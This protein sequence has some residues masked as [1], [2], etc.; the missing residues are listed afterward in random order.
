ML[1]SMRFVIKN[2]PKLQ[3]DYLVDHACGPRP[4]VVS[5]NSASRE[6]LMDRRLIRTPAHTERPAYT[7]LTDLGREVL[8]T[9]LADYADALVKAEL[10]QSAPTIELRSISRGRSGDRP[11]VALTQ[12]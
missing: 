2:M 10:L 9:I 12:I 4:I 3:R 11:P 5:E 6:A 1:P 8:C 7:E